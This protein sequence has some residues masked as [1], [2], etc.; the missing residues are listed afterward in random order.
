[1]R[2]CVQPLPLNDIQWLVLWSSSCPHWCSDGGTII[3][4]FLICQE[5]SQKTL[6][7]PPFV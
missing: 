4:K 2:G 7:K 5:Q 6:D 1:M 3:Q